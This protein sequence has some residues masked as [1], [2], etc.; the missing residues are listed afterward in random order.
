MWH[1]NASTDVCDTPNTMNAIRTAVIGVGHQGRWHADKFA[2]LPNS[3]L[4]AVVDAD[5]A[6]RDKAAAD[7]DVKSVADYRELLGNV[8]AVSIATPTPSHFEIVKSF[9]EHGTHVL[10]E[11]P[12][13]STVQEAEELVTLAEDRQLVLQ[14]GHLERF[15]PAVMAVAP[16]VS[17]PRFIESLRIAPYKPRGLDV[18]VVLDLMI[19]DIDLIHSF[20]GSRMVSVDAV[21]TTIFSRNI[22]IANARIR[23][24]NGCVANVTSSRISLKTERA[25]RIFE[26]NAYHSI[27]LFAKSTTSYRTKVEGPVEGPDDISIDAASFEASDALLEQAK[28]FLD[29]VSGGPPPLVSGRTALEALETAVAIGN[30]I[31]VQRT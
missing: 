27:D 7:L 22:D 29:S 16:T 5:A 25:I 30:Q 1:N 28:A 19:H 20:A 23:F 4:I 15:N 10:V 13:T 12:L 14:V 3:E 11:K 17:E 6:A 21:G 24:A 26:S 8:D 31:D 2:A 9:L 18:S